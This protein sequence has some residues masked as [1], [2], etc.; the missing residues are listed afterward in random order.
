MSNQAEAHLYQIKDRRRVDLGPVEITIRPT[1]N[2]G[3]ATCS[4]IGPA[5]YSNDA[6]MHQ[7]VYPDGSTQ[8]FRHGKGSRGKPVT[9]LLHPRTKPKTASPEA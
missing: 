8:L 2:P 6:T 7:F 9:G 5:E 1:D 4:F 3:V